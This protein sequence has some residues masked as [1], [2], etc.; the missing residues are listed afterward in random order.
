[1]NFWDYSQRTVPDPVNR[2]GTVYTNFVLQLNNTNT[3]ETI[4]L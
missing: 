2:E 3:V 4:P 1:M